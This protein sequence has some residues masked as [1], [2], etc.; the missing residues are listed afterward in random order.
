MQGNFRGP[1]QGRAQVDWLRSGS[2]YQVHMETS[3]A[4]LLTRR[5]SSEGELTERG[6]APRRFGRSFQTL[7]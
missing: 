6:L 5:I 7:S 1:I 4:P 2:R 3:V